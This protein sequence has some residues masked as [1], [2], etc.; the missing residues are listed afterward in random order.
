MATKV[1]EQ[2][3]TVAPPERKELTATG[4]PIRVSELISALSYALDLTEGRPMGHS[5]RACLIGMRLGA[6][7]GL[8]PA[9]LAD[10]Y[11]TLLMKD[12]GC[13]SNSSR[14]YHILNDDD[15]WTIVVYL[16]HLPPAGSLGEPRTY[17][18][19]EY[20]K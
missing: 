11:Y 15:M 18:G 5:V 19:D 7:L 3:R 6:A 14:L 17:S 1:L 16:R 12:A 13:S 8:S 20:A 9:A 4:G 2:L 10:L